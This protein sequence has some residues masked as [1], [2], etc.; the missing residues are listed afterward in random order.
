[1]VWNNRTP[2]LCYSRDWR[3]PTWTG[4][5]AMQHGLSQDTKKQRLTLFGSNLLDIAGKSTLAL[6]VDEVCVSKRC[7]VIS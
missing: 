7:R 5:Q 3:D 4:T 1:M 2:F 6:L